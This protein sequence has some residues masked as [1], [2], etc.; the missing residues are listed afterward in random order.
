MTSVAAVRSFIGRRR[1]RSWTDWYSAGF[2]LLIA[3]IYLADILASPL[4]RLNGQVS[5]AAA[6]HTA[7]L[8]AVTEAS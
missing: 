1:R 8:Q 7:A 2:A 6:T 5:Q 4:Q 3:G